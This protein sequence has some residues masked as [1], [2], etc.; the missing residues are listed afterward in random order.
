MAI[1]RLASMVPC[2]PLFVLLD[3]GFDGCR[4]LL[5]SEGRLREVLVKENRLVRDLCYAVWPRCRSIRYSS[6]LELIET[7]LGS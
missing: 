4:F 7:D 3:N 5:L 2:M 6:C 1:G